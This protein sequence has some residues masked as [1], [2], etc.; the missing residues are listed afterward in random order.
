VRRITVAADGLPGLH[1]REPVSVELQPV[2]ARWISLA[3]RVPA[4][5]AQIQTP[6][7]HEIHFT[8]TE[9]ALAD[10]SGALHLT[11]KSTFVLPRP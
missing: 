10:G 4:V 2:E 6:G 11:E 1:L 8:V 9:P 3:L 7:A 5:T